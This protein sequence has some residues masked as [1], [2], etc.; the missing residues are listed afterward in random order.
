M[1]YTINKTDGTILTVVEDGTLD[2]TTDLR[3]IGKNFQSF[4][5]VF[6]ENLVAL[7]ENFANNTA[8][9]KPL[10]GQLWYD[11]DD[12]ILSVFNGSIFKSLGILRLSSTAP[13]QNSSGDMWYDTS[14]QQLYIFNGSSYS[15]VGPVYTAS[16]GESGA[17][18]ETLNG[19][20]NST[21]IVTKF[22]SS[23]TTLAYLSPATFTP[24]PAVTGFTEIKA[25]I[26][27]NETL[28]DLKFQGT[29]TN[30]DEVDS[31]DSSQFLR[32]DVAN[33]ATGKLTINNDAGI[34]LGSNG[35][36]TFNLQSDDFVL[37]NEATN[38]DILF[39][40]T[41]SSSTETVLTLDGS[42]KNVIVA[43]DLT[44][45]NVIISDDLTVGNN[46]TAITL[47]GTVAT[48]NQ[49]NITSVGT[50]T[51]LNVS[52]NI[53]SG[54]T[55]TALRLSGEIQ[56]GTQTN[57]T[58]VGTLTNL[59]VSGTATV[60]TLVTT[61][62]TGTITTPNQPNINQLGVLSSLQVSGSATFNNGIN[63]ASGVI[64][65][66]I[67][68]GSQTGITQV[69]TLTGLTV[70]GTATIT[71]LSLSN[72]LSVANGGTGASTAADART[73]LGAVNIA[74]DTMTGLLTLSGVPTATNH[75]ATKGYTDSAI[76]SA[77]TNYATKS[78]ADSTAKWQ[79]ANKWVST[80]E[81]TSSDGQDGDIWFVREA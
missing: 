24:T 49:P 2:T 56:D 77:L 1:S 35:L 61:N 14:N 69:G 21:N 74:G 64:S 31:L 80:S 26:T 58:E 16:Q 43:N 81:P 78:Y 25:G 15:L 11:T 70:G 75:A 62:L 73:N 46:F 29:A 66:T 71:T 13:S 52:N 5:E 57:I 54:N 33:T 30:A 60:G 18:V 48:A 47:T 22:V 55:V 34:T 38:K 7:L 41:D 28:T 23:G 3:L 6:N 17:F 8:P 65:G 44:A 72:D 12:S 27:F 50:L 79:G 45:G 36:L 9:P 63:V 19:T 40:V 59:T 76:S 4:G 53:T 20:D 67:G 42:T 39:Q 37:F 68:T 32:L 51:S 10:S